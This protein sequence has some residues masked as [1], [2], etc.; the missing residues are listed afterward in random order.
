MDFQFIIIGA[1]IG[2]L[3]PL[4]FLIY[5]GIDIDDIRRSRVPLPE[6]PKRELLWHTMLTAVIS[7]AVGGAVGAIV[8]FLI[9]LLTTTPPPN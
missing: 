8:G 7:G 1:I 5:P 4:F 3:L 9:H 2:F 6:P